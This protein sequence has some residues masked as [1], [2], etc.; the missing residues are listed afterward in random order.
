MI[1]VDYEGNVSPITAVLA[2]DSRMDAA[3]VQVD[4]T[5]TPLPLNDAVQPGDDAFYFSNP[6]DQRGYFSRGMVNRFY[7]DSVNRG[8]DDANLKA[9][10]RLRLNVSTPWAPGSSGSPV[11]DAQGNAIG[12][13]TVIQAMGKQPIH[14]NDP[15][16]KVTLAELNITLHSAIPARRVRALVQ[17]MKPSL[18]GIV[19][20]PQQA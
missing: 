15:D 20:A 1:A 8:K 4:Q 12:H 6:L 14:K 10:R 18:V 5:L 7:W 13:V 3:I 2:H 9:L 11:L 17:S 19:P 16:T